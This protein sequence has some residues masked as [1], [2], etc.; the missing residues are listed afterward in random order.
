MDLSKAFDTLNHRLLLAKLKAYG[1]QPTALKQME[2]Y[3]TGCFQRTKISHKYSSWSKIIA[4]IPQGSVLGPL[5]FNI[6]L[7][8]LF[9]Y[10]EETFLSNYA[11]DNTLYSIGNTIERVKKALSNDFRIIQNWFRENVMVLNA[12]KCH[13]MRFG[14]GSEN[15]DFIFDG[16]KLPNSC[17]EKI[18]GVIINNELKFVPY[19]RSMC[20][21]AA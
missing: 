6:F 3:L 8:D 2:N 4:V 11:D 20:K 14:I 17:V 16:I 19:S 7:N 12:K 1:L 9:L 18:L 21:K 15:D 5:V 13:Y 10:P